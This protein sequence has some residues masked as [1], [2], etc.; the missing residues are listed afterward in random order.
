M[1]FS[2]LT[3]SAPPSAFARRALAVPVDGM[4][5]RRPIEAERGTPA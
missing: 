4:T 2:I 3:H 1:L 5:V